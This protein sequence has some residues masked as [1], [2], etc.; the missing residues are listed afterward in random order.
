MRKD[1]EEEKREYLKIVE[2][3][4]KEKVRKWPWWKQAGIHYAP[5]AYYAKRY[6]P[7]G[8]VPIA[9]DINNYRA[10]MIFIPVFFMTSVMVG[11]ITNGKE[12]WVVPVFFLLHVAILIATHILIG[13]RPG[14]K[15]LLRFT[16]HGLWINQEDYV[17]KWRYMVRSGIET[18]TTQDSTTNN[19]ILHFYDERY[20]CF[21][22]IA[23]DTCDLAIG[24]KELC[25]YVEYFKTQHG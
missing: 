16:P 6:V 20:D 3:A 18:D 21:R 4:H 10:G 5:T 23:I 24:N 8:E 25:F 13:N 1:F 2:A 9:I 22:E 17:V 15:I 11:M 7:K 12:D 14:K 19:L